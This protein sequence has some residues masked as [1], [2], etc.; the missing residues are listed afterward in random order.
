MCILSLVGAACDSRMTEEMIARFI[1]ALKE[2]TNN[3]TTQIDCERIADSVVQKLKG[4]SEQ[5]E[6][7][8]F[9]IGECFQETDDEKLYCVPC[10]KHTSSVLFPSHL[11]PGLRGNYGFFDKPD[12]PNYKANKERKKRMLDH[13]RSEIHSWCL[14]QEKSATAKH[15][16]EAKLNSRCAEILVTSAFHCFLEL[17]GS[18]KQVRLNSLLE[19]LM[20]DEYPTQND[21]RQH[22]FSIRE[23]AFDKL[24]EKVRE[25]FKSVKSACFTLDKVTV[26]RTP[27]TVI[28]TYFF[29][30]GRIHVLLNS[31]HKMKV[32]E[33]D[34]RGSAEMVG[35]VLMKS[36]GLTREE[37]G[38]I[39]RHGIYDGVYA[40]TDERVAGGGSLS[41]MHHF[42]DWCQ[43]PE[44]Y[45]S[46]HW[47][48]GHKLQLVYGTILKKNKDV[49]SFNNTMEKVMQKC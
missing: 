24:T 20:S 28:M 32:E 12:D 11:K 36:L 29:F 35:N 8:A 40:S 30:E 2:A 39:F 16:A 49:S 43:L 44:H 37:V 45:F 21:G 6:V 19:M 25:N 7:E 38:K 27:F 26:R 15:D 34:G 33:Y 47:D 18:L 9:E 31:V 10:F 22:F 42:A 1:D 14:N 41:L 46:G 5:S 48:V 17:D 13:T 23:I 4:A 3:I